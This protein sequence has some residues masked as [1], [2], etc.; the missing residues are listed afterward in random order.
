MEVCCAS[1][2]VKEDAQRS[3]IGFIEP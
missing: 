1:A 2:K 3:S